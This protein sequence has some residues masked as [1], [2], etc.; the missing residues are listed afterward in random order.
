MHWHNLGQDITRCL[1]HTG[2]LSKFN[3]CFDFTKVHIS[4]VNLGST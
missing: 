1:L 2:G 4:G 3:T